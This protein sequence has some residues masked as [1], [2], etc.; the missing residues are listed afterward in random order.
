MTTKEVVELIK[1][2]SSAREYVNLQIGE[3]FDDY[4]VLESLEE[5]EDHAAQ[6]TIPFS[7]KLD[8][9]SVIFSSY[10][11]SI[12]FETSQQALAKSLE[13]RLKSYRPWY[14]IILEKQSALM[15]LLTLISG[16]FYLYMDPDLTIFEAVV[17]VSVTYLLIGF[18]IFQLNLKYSR[19]CI[20][21]VERSGFWKRSSDKI[22]TAVIMLLIGVLLRELLM[23][24]AK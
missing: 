5:I 6:I 3:I 16:L 21:H 11:C 8:G 20:V 13:V 12:S 1:S 2:I 18:T 10:D 17:L 22:W 23:Y 24:F 19:P 9:L 15:V 14:H 4:T 7:I